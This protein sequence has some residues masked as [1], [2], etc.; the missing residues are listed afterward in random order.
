MLDT[1]KP[2]YVVISAGEG[3]RYDHP[4]EEALK[5]FDDVGAAVLRTDEQ[6]T[7]EIV[8]DGQWMWWEGGDI[9]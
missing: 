6:G 4:Y 9:D 2:Q 8:T 5:R 3:N 1:I 7:I